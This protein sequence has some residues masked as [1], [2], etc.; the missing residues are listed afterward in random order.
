METGECLIQVDYS[1]GYHNKDQDEIQSAYFGHETFSIFTAC[2]YFRPNDSAKLEKV[3]L[4]IVSEANDHSRIASFTC[5]SKVIECIEERLP[6]LT[7]LRRVYIWSDGCA[8]QFRSRYVFSLLTHLHP[9]KDIEW[10]Y[11]EAH[12]GKGPMDGIGGTIKNKVFQEVKSGRIVVTSPEDFARH[13]GKLVES[14]TTLYLP[15]KDIMPEPASIET[16]PYIKGTLEV[17][18]VVR[19][20]NFQRV[21]YTWN[22]FGFP[23]TKILFIL[24]TIVTTMTL[25][26]AGTNR[27]MRALISVPIAF[28]H[29]DKENSGWNVQSVSNGTVQIH[30]FHH[31]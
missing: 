16:A 7:S 22:F 12:H 24:N 10:N 29:T 5:V 6:L 3:P 31:N 13:A 30:V 23:Q 14:V 8:S 9:S 17:H 18:R 2:G 15:S 20:K 25:L 1:E 11:N 27:L 19:R 26:F 28:Q 21:M 4:T